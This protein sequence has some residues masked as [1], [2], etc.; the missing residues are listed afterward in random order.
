MR[1]NFVLDRHGEEVL[2]RTH[3]EMGWRVKNVP[4]HFFSGSGKGPQETQAGTESLGIWPAT[5]GL[6]VLCVVGQ[7]V[8]VNCP[9][10]GSCNS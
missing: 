6:P 3:C 7:G 8:S 2:K 10:A 4:A 9:T 5:G 1:K